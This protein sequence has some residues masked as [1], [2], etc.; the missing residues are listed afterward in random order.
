MFRSAILLVALAACPAKNDPPKPPTQP[1]PPAQTGSGSAT[2]K[3]VPA[4]AVS[5]KTDDD[6]D[7][8]AC[9]PCNA[10]DVLT[11]QDVSIKCLRNPCPQTTVSCKNQV[12]T[13]N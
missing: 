7:S 10:G 2:P 1:T 3:P 8:H 12:C 5:C 11:K 13:V 4:D 6:Q 9:G